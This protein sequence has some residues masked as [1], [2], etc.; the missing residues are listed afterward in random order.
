MGIG[1]GHRGGSSGG[2]NG[3]APSP[4]AEV[5]S[6]RLLG[7]APIDL[8]E[9]RFSGYLS[10]AT[11]LV[12]G[13]AGSIGNHLCLRLAQSG[14]HKLVLVDQAEAALVELAR[15]LEH[16]GFTGAVPVL[17][18]VRSRPRAV[19]IFERHRPDVVF[20][21][22][23]YK[24]VP[25]LEANP[26]EAVAVNVLG[27]D[28]VV[29]AA[30][31]VGVERF[32]LFSTDKAVEPVSVLGRTKAIA[33]WIVGTAGSELSQGQYVAVRLGNVADSAG[34]F[35]PTFRRQLATGGPVA[36]TH[37]GAMRYLM[38]LDEAAA[39]AIVAG[40][41]SD[42]SGIFW[43]DLQPPVRVID[44]VERLVDATGTGVAVEFVGLRPG[45]RLV[46]PLVREGDQVEA[47]PCEHV[48]RSPLDT[49]D[50]GWL[51]TWISALEHYVDHASERA[52]RFA[53][54]EM[55]A[56]RKRDA[57]PAPEALVT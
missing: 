17:A 3:R 43:L 13:A 44:L 53:L 4:S 50:G 28:R 52:V 25:L 46:E 27:T 37:P 48:F 1:A 33:E 40:A 57:A 32:V 6:A 42:S 16:Q 21:A 8:G 49:V 20:H 34:S 5:T 41:L 47:T 10:G 9:D 14:V 54:D 11:V 24:Q 45:E 2:S 19:A 35:L 23:A 31:H 55:H 56:A 39:L 38:T 7:R 36:V 51:S 30:R 29:G 18:D 15:K 26:V 12:T 22:A